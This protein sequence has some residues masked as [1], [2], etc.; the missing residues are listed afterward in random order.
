MHTKLLKIVLIAALQKNTGNP[1][2]KITPHVNTPLNSSAQTSTLTHQ[3]TLLRPFAG[4]E[5]SAALQ[6]VQKVGFHRYSQWFV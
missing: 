3:L 6:E 2:T 5:Y 1:D 4:L